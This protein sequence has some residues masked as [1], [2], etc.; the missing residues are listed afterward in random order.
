MATPIRVAVLFPG[1]RVFVRD[2]RSCSRKS[3]PRG[4][5]A[6]WTRSIRPPNLSFSVPMTISPSGGQR[7]RA[8]CGA[9]VRP[10]PTSFQLVV[11]GSKVSSIV[12]PP[13]SPPRGLVGRR[14][15]PIQVSPAGQD[16]L[17]TVG[18][19]CFCRR[20]RR[21]SASLN[22]CSGMRV[23]ALVGTAT[24]AGY[25]AHCCIGALHPWSVGCTTG[26][27]PSPFP[28][29]KCRTRAGRAEPRGGDEQ[30]PRDDVI[31]RQRVLVLRS[32][33]TPARGAVSR[34][35]AALCVRVPNLNFAVGPAAK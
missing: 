14:L 5:P 8:P 16:C 29:A 23:R 20:A 22:A 19:T 13:Q 35:V 28:G 24:S 26:R 1:P 31:G 21:R 27:F 4:R 3:G 30:A 25:I 18:T 17:G 11:S 34:D 10:N 32:G 2:A 33:P 9:T 15:R 6:K 12:R 7:E